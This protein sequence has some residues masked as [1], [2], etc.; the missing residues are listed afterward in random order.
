MAAVTT[1]FLQVSFSSGK[2]ASFSVI[3]LINLHLKKGKRGYIITCN[4][5]NL[6]KF[7]AEEIPFK[8]L[9]VLKSSRQIVNQVP[10][11][12]DVCREFDQAR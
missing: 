5:Q 2:S 12:T 10:D 3:T 1:D 6:L 9:H 8:I 7:K 11:V 4:D